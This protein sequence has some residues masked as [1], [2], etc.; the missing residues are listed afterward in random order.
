MYKRNLE[1]KNPMRM[2]AVLLAAGLG[3][4]LAPI[5][6]KTPKCL[7]PIHGKPLLAYWLELC[8]SNGMFP[9]IV[10]TQYLEDEVISFVKC[11]YWSDKVLLYHEENLLGTGGTLLSLEKYLKDGAFFVAHAD[12]LSFFSMQKFIA[13]HQQRPENCILTMMT[14]RTPTPQSCGIVDVDDAGIV[15]GFYEKIPNP[16]SDLANGA[17]FI[18]EPEVLE[19]LGA[20]KKPI[21]DISIDVLPK[22]LGRMATFLNDDYHRDVGTLESYGLAQVEM[23]ARFLNRTRHE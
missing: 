10:N 18:M 22:C 3:T 19:V 20:V 14:F 9:V 13:S 5:T 17:V 4:R 8:C 6:N 15:K 23:Y 21:S 1:Q 16:P 2:P 11:S 12:N 7:V